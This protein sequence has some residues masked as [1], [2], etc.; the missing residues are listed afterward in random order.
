MPA[1]DGAAWGRGATLLAGGEGGR[2]G[3]GVGHSA[4]DADSSSSQ[5]VKRCSS[6]ASSSQELSAGAWGWA[7]GGAKGSDSG[8][9]GAS[10]A[11]M[12]GGSWSA[13]EMRS[14]SGV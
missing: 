12:S 3:R 10:T 8:L 4:R 13:S 1:V 6:Q 11:V 9:R 2:E 14:P 5:E 7:D